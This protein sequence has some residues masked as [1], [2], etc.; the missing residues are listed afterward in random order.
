MSPRLC[1][2]VTHSN[3]LLCI[4][5]GVC[6]PTQRDADGAFYNDTLRACAAPPHALPGDGSQRERAAAAA[7]ALGD[8]TA[9]ALAA[10]GLRLFAGGAGHTEWRAAAAEAAAGTGG[11]TSTDDGGDSG[12]DELE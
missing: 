9:D 8:A 1:V 11:E 6:G 2:L 7:A 3:V 4:A 5:Q 10:A 12:A